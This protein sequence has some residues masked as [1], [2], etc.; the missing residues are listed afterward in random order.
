MSSSIPLK[1][2]KS[3]KP[4]GPLKAFH[5]P[6]SSSTPHM[7]KKKLDG[8]NGPKTYWTDSEDSSRLLSTAECS[9]QSTGSPGSIDENVLSKN[10]SP[11][12][13]EKSSLK[14]HFPVIVGIKRNNSHLFDQKK[15]V[16]N[17]GNFPCACCCSPVLPPKRA[18]VV[19]GAEGL[20][21]LRGIPSPFKHLNPSATPPETSLAPVC[22]VPM[23]PSFLT[24]QPHLDLDFPGRR[25]IASQTS[26]LEI[27]KKKSKRRSSSANGGGV[28]SSIKKKITSLKSSISTDKFPSRALFR[29]IPSPMKIAKPTNSSSEVTTCTL[30][31]RF[32]DGSRVVQLRR[33]C[34]SAQ[35][36][37]YVR[38]DEDKGMIVS[39]I[40]LIK[41]SE[42]NNFLNRGDRVLEVEHIPSSKL[43]CDGMRKLLDGR[44]TATLKVADSSRHNEHH[45]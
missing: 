8:R 32:P 25:S 7:S 6:N 9:S 5:L 38:D 16:E 28:L 36:G 23:P 41:F 13:V 43:D 4:R 37:L 27:D 45:N 31:Q 33:A 18:H 15:D 3:D 19:M 39:R 34:P 12:G 44:L 24:P 42:K 30:L 21:L 10:P 22:P 2:T 40:G 1:R 14:Q 17:C 35:F 29:D 11:I 20:K 26:P